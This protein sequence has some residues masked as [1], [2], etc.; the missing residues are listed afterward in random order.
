MFVVAEKSGGSI[1]E[2]EGFF[3]NVVGQATMLNVPLNKRLVLDVAS[4]LS[5]VSS[6][7]LINVELIQKEVA[8]FYGTTVQDLSLIH[9]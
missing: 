1:R 2:L 6:V 3:N 5:S 8:S 9:I 4:R 7:D